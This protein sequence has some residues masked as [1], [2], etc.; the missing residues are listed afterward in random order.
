MSLLLAVKTTLRLALGLVNL[1]VLFVFLA[2]AAR[3]GEQYVD[4]EGR[5]VGGH[6]V[7]T[8]HTEDSPRMAHADITADYNGLTWHFVSEDNRDLFLADPRRYV[9]A[10]DGHCAYAMA[11]GN[12]VR[13]DQLA[14]RAVNGVLY[15]NFNRNIQERWDRDI[16][17]YLERSEANWPDLEDEPA[18]SPRGWFF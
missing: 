12:K 2:A 17:G 14:Y 8:Y 15:M 9:P 10:Y 3:A 11:N 5:P 6:D 13:S 1:G 18:A 7:I 4:R 16:P